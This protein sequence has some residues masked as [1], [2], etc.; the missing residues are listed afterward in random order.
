MNRRYTLSDS[1]YSLIMAALAT[2]ADKHFAKSKTLKRESES[3]Y[4]H[5]KYLSVMQ[6][7]MELFEQKRVQ[8]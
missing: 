3:Q 1:E 8:A 5:E 6:V 7:K 4:H 2:E